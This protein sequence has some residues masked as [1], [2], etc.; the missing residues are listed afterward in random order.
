V[1]VDEVNPTT[2]VITN[3]S[4]VQGY[5]GTYN[6]SVN[7]AGIADLAG[8]P[9]MGSTNESWQ[10]IL[11][12]P[13][14][15]PPGG[16]PDTGISSTDGLTDTNSLVLSGTLGASNLIARVFDVTKR[17]VLGTAIVNG[18]NFSEALT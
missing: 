14:S 1:L 7:A 3:F 10:I 8:N 11:V 2:F 18:T 9:A 6:L 5:A 12:T 16:Q 13:A 15:L 4:W 17:H